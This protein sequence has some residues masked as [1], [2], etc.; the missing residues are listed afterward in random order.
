MPVDILEFDFTVQPYT[1]PATVEIA[2]NCNVFMA[3]N[4]G[5]V[6][7]TA[8]SVNGF[9]INAPL[10]VGTNGEA[11]IMGGNKGEIMK[12]KTIDLAFP[13]GIAGVR[14]LIVQKFYINLK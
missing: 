10:A 2:A 12:R 6:G 13:L 11:F 3:I 7:S 8:A 5:A 14:V 9:P 1:Q 4:V